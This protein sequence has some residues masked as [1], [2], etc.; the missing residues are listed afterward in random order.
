ME[1]KP[2]AAANR[3]YEDFDPPSNWASEPEHDTLILELPGFKKEQLRVQV[4]SN[5]SLKIT[6]ERSLGNNKWRRFQKEFPVPSNVDPNSI[7]AKFEGGMLYVKHPKVITALPGPA[8][9]E[10]A[11]PPAKAPRPEQMPKSD[12]PQAKPPAQAPRPEQMPKSDQPQQTQK[13]AQE[14]SSSKSSNVDKPTTIG[15]T[16][17]PVQ[18]NANKGHDVND[19]N[20]D[21]SQKTPEKEKEPSDDAANKKKSTSPDADITAGTS[22]E[23]QKRTPGDSVVKKSEKTDKRAVTGNVDAGLKSDDQ[24]EGYKRSVSSL[25]TELTK[26]KTLLNLIVAGLMVLVFVLY[27]KN[28]VKPIGGPKSEHP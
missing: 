14:V 5:R 20:R 13:A 1:A 4:T 3:V 25:A 7:T 24:Q 27:L 2:V 8:R 19:A 17:A 11:K 6:G 16:T 9:P 26:P 15:K 28:A 23:K 22:H 10:Q 21:I 12:Q 18:A